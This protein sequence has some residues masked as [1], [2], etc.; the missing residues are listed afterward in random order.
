MFFFFDI[1]ECRTQQKV[2]PNKN[3][4]KKA[5]KTRKAR[6]FNRNKKNCKRKTRNTKNRNT[7][8]TKKL[9]IKTLGNKRDNNRRIE[10]LEAGIT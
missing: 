8:W 5:I 10:K 4:K 1:W 9:K 3:D 7:T 2:E 6:N